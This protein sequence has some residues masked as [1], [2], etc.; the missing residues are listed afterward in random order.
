MRKETNK[1]GIS[2]R[3]L[4]IIFSVL[5]SFALWFFIS[6]NENQNMTAD[7]N[8]IVV[9]YTGEE[10]LEG[11]NLI[12]TGVDTEKLSIRVSGKR[13][14][15]ARLSK[16]DITVNVDMSDISAAGTHFLE[17]SVDIASESAADFD[18]VSATVNHVTV[19]VEKMVTVPVY[20]RGNYNGEIADGYV[21]GTLKFSPATIEI[22]GPEETVSSVAYAWVVLSRDSISKTVTDKLPFT[23]MDADGKAVDTEYIRT[24]TSEIE[25][26]Q[27]VSLLK[28]VP[29]DINRVYGAGATETNTVVSIEPSY[30]TV[31]GDAG[32]IDGLNKIVLG[33]ID[34]STFQ[35]TY[36]SEF[37][38]V[39]P[40]DTINRTGISTASV[41]VRVVGLETT[42]L[43][44]SNISFTNSTE[45]YR[46]DIITQTMDITLRGS[47]EAIDNISADN[48]RVV[49]NLEG[50]GNAEGTFEVEAKVYVDGYTDIGPLGTYQVNVRVQKDTLPYMEGN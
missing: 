26:T 44:V 11:K 12:V 50:L 43:S 45:G 27:E 34:L 2:Q 7:F 23:L 29:L 4:Y 8:G 13:L 35:S 36:T 6:A 30:I 5:I 41:T 32:A 39:I 1:L 16:E 14:A 42:K 18:V 49:A 38:I 10:T 33:T 40:D 22:S 21:S 46:A 15:V 48:I 28:D 3:L 20:V 31:S 17:Y 47:K 25:V 24:T 37:R 19:T 9:H